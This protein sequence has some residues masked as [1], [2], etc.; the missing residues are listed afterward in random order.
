MELA[1]PARVS[2]PGSACPCLWA[3]PCTEVCSVLGE[4]WTFASSLTRS[5]PRCYGFVCFRSRC[6]PCLLLALIWP[7]LCLQC[8]WFSASPW[9]V[10]ISP[11]LS[12]LPRYRDKHPIDSVLVALAYSPHLLVF[13]APLPLSSHSPQHS[14]MAFSSPSSMGSL[15]SKPAPQ[16]CSS[17]HAS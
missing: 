14:P 6:L 7:C 2:L 13:S 3:E 5:R 12:G 11:R 10:Q 15:G 9:L 17:S 4:Y 16:L 8:T 1:E